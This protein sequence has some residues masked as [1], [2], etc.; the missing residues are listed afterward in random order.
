MNNPVSPFV[1]EFNKILDECEVFRYITRD[2]D[3]Q[4]HA[5][6]RLR[7]LLQ[8]TAAEKK[9][10]AE[11]GDEDYANVLLGCECAADALIHE[12]K[13][14]LLLKDGRPDEAWDALVAAQSSL[15]F[16]IRAHRGFARLEGTVRRLEVVEDIAFPPQVFLSTG[17]IVKSQVCSICGGEY[18]DCEHVRDDRIWEGSVQSL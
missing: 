16:A 18:E 4:K 9:A 5:C 13:M 14:W 1:A 2:S 7:G 8:R 3:L 12:I 10:A 17:M 15:S 6:E 11:Y